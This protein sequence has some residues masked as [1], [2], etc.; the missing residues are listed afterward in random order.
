MFLVR[1]HALD[2]LHIDDWGDEVRC[3]NISARQANHLAAREQRPVVLRL[4]RR[5]VLAM[6]VDEGG[7]CITLFADF[8]ILFGGVA[9]RL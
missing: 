6:D 8:T 7:H 3:R 4:L 5:A 9:T 2:A 1:R